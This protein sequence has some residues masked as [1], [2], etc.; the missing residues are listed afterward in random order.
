MQFLDAFGVKPWLL[1]AQIVNFLILLFVLK[2]FAYK[3]I[4]NIFHERKSKIEESMKK[5]E[6]IEKRLQK[7]HQEAEGILRQAQTESTQIIAQAKLQAEAEG[8]R[9]M[10][11]TQAK[12]QQ[13]VQVLE[14]KKKGEKQE[15]MQELKGD[16]TKLVVQVSTKFLASK[17]SAEDDEKIL[18]E[19]VKEI[20]SFK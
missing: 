15:I 7:A 13:I 4:L 17:A 9:I 18:S 12:A 16:L 2:K 14:E 3:P 11:E 5:A 20:P 19:V 6:E 1:L 10:G 8:K